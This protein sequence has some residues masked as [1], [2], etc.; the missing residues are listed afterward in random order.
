[1]NMLHILIINVLMNEENFIKVADEV[2]VKLL[3]L[4]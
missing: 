4:N 3:G 1:M 2:L